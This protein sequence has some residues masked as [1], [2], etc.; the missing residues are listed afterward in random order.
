MTRFAYILAGGSSSRM[1]TDKLHLKLKGLSLLERIIETCAS[2]CDDIKLVGN[3]VG[4]NQSETFKVL[5]DYPHARGPMAGVISA[6]EDCPEDICFITAADLIDITPQNLT[7]LFRLYRVEQFLGYSEDGLSQ[8]LCGIYHKSALKVMLP[9]A[10][11]G[12]F[13]MQDAVG[14]LDTRLLP[15]PNKKWR[16]INTPR[17]AELSGVEL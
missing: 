12:N 4:I 14:K 7:D 1:G 10:E 8:P 5:S 15:V 3:G 2:V 16:N 6:L 17:D 9:M 11:R 13:K